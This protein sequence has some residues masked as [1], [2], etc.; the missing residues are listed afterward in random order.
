MR[1]SLAVYYS[2]V[3]QTLLMVAVLSL[4]LRKTN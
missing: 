4:V 1:R 2:E 3:D